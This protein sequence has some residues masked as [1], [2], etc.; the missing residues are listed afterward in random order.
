[1]EPDAVVADPALVPDPFGVP[2]LAVSVRESIGALRAAVRAGAQGFYLWPGERDALLDAV[3]RIVGG[4]TSHER[5]AEVIAI[6]GGRGGVGTT[7][8]ATHLAA[9]IGRTGAVAVLVDADLDGGDVGRVLG[10]TGA[11]VRTFAD[12]VPVA[13]ELTWGHL[14]EVCW[15]GALLAPPPEAR[16]AV[17]DALVR[18]AVEVAAANADAVVLHLPRAPGGLTRWAADAADRLVEILTL[19]VGAFRGAARSLELRGVSNGDPRLGFVVNR[20]ARSEITPGDV[21]RVFGVDPVAVIPSDPVVVRSQDHGR[22]AP[23][24]GRIGRAFDRLAATLLDPPG[25]ARVA[26]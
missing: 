6:H 5:R 1:L 3:Q 18:R 12:L 11:D 22:L 10:A 23:P 2:L 21:R 16:E 7:F 13:D 25:D 19:D 14:D 4:R 24:R 26:S 8:V 15:E 9:A 20:A 17:D